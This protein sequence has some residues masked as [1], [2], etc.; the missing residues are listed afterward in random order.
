MIDVTVLAGTPGRVQIVI[1][2]ADI[3]T[4]SVWDITWEQDGHTGAPR[5]GSGVGAGEQVVVVDAAAPVGGTVVYTLRVG[6]SVSSTASASRPF[7]GG[8]ILADLTGE[9]IAAFSWQGDDPREGL[10]RFHV[11]D[12]DGSR[13]PPI[14]YAPAGDGGGALVAATV[15]PHTDT[16]R[17]LLTS[18]EPL[19][20]LHNADECDVPGCDVPPSEIVYIT[21]DGNSR[22]GRWGAAERLWSLSYVLAPDPEP[23]YRAST[24]T[25][26]DLDAAALTWDTLDSMALTWDG[27]DRTDWTQVGA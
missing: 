3:P 1:P 14:R 10:R 22:G 9:T 8:S 16:L 13:R 26:D 25:W 11:S 5:G 20:L 21:A 17:A 7:S 4:G 24:S 27:F 23:G 12:V 18:G 6:G 15:R 2:G 19:L